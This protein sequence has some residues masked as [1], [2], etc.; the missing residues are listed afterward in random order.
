MTSREQFEA[1]IGE[2]QGFHGIDLEWH[3]TRNCYAQFGIHLAWCAWRASREVEIKL[4][5]KRGH[6]NVVNGFVLPEAEQYD[7]AIDDCDDSIKEAGFKV[8]GG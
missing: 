8:K 1:W 4:P 6:L 3:Q 2:E 7:E 5:E